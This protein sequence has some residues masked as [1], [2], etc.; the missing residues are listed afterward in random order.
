MTM[1]RTAGFRCS[2]I[3][4]VVLAACIPATWWLG[5]N[6]GP[7]AGSVPFAAGHFFLFCNVFRIQRAK[8]LLWAAVCLVNVGAWML[9]ERFDWWLILAGQSPL[10]VVLIAW[11]MRGPHYHGL[12]A[13]RINRRLDEY[14]DGRLAE[15]R[16]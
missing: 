5:G 15:G 8:E 14:L 12:W 3:D 11:E 6:V 7:I 1:S 10:T 4:L 9:A 13:R 16:H 2:S